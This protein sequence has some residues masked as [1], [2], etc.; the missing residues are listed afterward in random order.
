MPIHKPDPRKVR[1]T[2]RSLRS[3]LPRVG[4]DHEGL[5]ELE[6]VTVSIRAPV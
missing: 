2:R 5:H 1:R 4:G 3:A 6:Y